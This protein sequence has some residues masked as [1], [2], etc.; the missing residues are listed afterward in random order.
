MFST[1]KKTNLANI[2][3]FAVILSVTAF[4]IW[5]SDIQ[6]LMIVMGAA[7]GYL[8]GKSQSTSNTTVLND[9]NKED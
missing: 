1:L 9:K 4:L 2:A 3:S 5:V 8:F 6:S 7:I